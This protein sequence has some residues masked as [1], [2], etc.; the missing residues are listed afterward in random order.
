MSGA[1]RPPQNPLTGAG[2]RG[3][4]GFPCVT[5]TTCCAASIAALPIIPATLTDERQSHP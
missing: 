3:A 1:T 5:Q 2:L 4:I